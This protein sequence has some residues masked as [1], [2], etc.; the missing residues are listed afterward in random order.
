MKQF[1]L[2]SFAALMTSTVAFPCS[3]TVLGSTAMPMAFALDELMSMPSDDLVFGT[4]VKNVTMDNG[5]VVI[6]TSNDKDK[7]ETFTY[8]VDFSGNCMSHHAIL[9]SRKPCT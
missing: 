5:L 1:V 3:L 7:C 9:K 4:F 8:E 6:T 2:L